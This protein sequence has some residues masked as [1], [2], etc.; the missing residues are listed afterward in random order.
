MTLPGVERLHGLWQDG[1]LTANADGIHF[2]LA[3]REIQVWS[4]LP[5]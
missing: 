4:T 2:A 3:P 5:C 1:A